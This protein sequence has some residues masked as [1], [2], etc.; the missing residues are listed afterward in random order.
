MHLCTV[1]TQFACIQCTD[2]RIKLL[3]PATISPRTKAGLLPSDVE[4]WS[5]DR[6]ADEAVRAIRSCRKHGK[7]A[8]QS[9]WQAG[10]YLSLLDHGASPLVVCDHVR[11]NAVD[12]LQAGTPLAQRCGAP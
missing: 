4:G 3:A 8:A 1:C 12:L 6:L 9:A 5:T 2:L 10:A 7:A 11:R